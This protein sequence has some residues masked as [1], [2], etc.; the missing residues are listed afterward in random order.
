MLAAKAVVEWMLSSCPWKGGLSRA[1]RRSW[2]VA[3]Q[4]FC[5]QNSTHELRDLNRLSRFWVL[6]SVLFVWA[7]ITCFLFYIYVVV[8]PMA[9][10]CYVGEPGLPPRNHSIHLWRRGW[11]CLVDHLDSEM[12]QRGSASVVGIEIVYTIPFLYMQCL[13]YNYIYIYIYM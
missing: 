5:K 8:V 2:T 1:G 10:P 3:S 4:G 7:H 9:S 11:L 6:H 13:P 12:I